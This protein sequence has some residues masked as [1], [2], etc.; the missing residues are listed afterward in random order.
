MRTL[1]ATG[2]SIDEAIFNGLRELQISIDEVEIDI[3]QQETKGVF[4]I[5]AKPA[6][7]RLIE[8]EPEQIVIPDYIANKDMPRERRERR[9]RRD[10]RDRRDRRD[11]QERAPRG[12]ETAVAEAGVTEGTPAE[13]AAAECSPAEANAERAPR[14]RTP[15]E[16]RDRG[17]RRE[18]TERVPALQHPVIEYS[19][20]A[21]EGNPAADFL[22]G[23]L[24]AMGVEA[25]V[26][27]NVSEEGIRLRI[28]SASM[29]ILI[30]HRGETL[31]A[32]QYLTSLCINRSR[33]ETGYTRVTIDTEGYRDKRE[34]TLTRLARKI[35]SQVK[36][37]GRAR[38]LEPMNPYERRVLH[39]TLQNNPY[40]T[41][42][43]EGE[44]P[45]R[46]V[47]IAPRKREER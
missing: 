31:D 15:R 16:R 29:G 13:N 8:R 36:A 43:S 12:V 25:T 20:E 6:I 9:D 22:K 7:V 24:A 23:L 32:I 19:A 21:A 38:T 2:K 42:Y 37:T 47:V 33:K 41:T 45:N 26:L 5:G 46:R 11:R 3:I 1:E 39:A 17:N 27:A 35:A 14:E 34:E 18:S 44:E 4:G 40:V 28:D 10:N 30:G